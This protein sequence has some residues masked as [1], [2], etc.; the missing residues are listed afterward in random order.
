MHDASTADGPQEGNFGAGG[1]SL[2]SLILKSS[3]GL[4]VSD[5]VLEMSKISPAQK[6]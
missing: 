5:T 1:G 3:E 4:Y 6:N 2:H